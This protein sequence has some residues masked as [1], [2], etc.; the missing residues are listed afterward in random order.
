MNEWV[1][2]CVGWNMMVNRLGSV[3]GI[4]ITLH[5]VM[6]MVRIVYAP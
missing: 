1:L 3:L 2:A 6:Y 4:G 5:E